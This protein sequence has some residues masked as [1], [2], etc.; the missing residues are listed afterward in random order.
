[1]REKYYVIDGTSYHKS[2]NAL[3]VSILEK[4]MKT[5]TRVRLFL[6]DPETGEMWLEEHDVVGC[7]GRSTG[8]IKIPLLVGSKR[9]SGGSGVLDDC[10]IAIK[11]KEAW[12]Y[13]HDKYK[14][15]AFDFKGRDG[16]VLLNGKVYANFRT[17]SSAERWVNFMQGVRF[18]R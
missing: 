4:Y 13:K 17:E 5:N 12:V 1:M 18:T 7:I 14:M 8:D 11:T 10:I 3:V 15:P 6:G 9:S 16:A 2:T